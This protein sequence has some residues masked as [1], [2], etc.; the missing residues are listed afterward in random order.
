[1]ALYSSAAAVYTPAQAWA[2]TG[3]AT[4][5][6]GVIGIL[7]AKIVANRRARVIYNHMDDTG[8]ALLDALDTATKGLE[9]P[10]ADHPRSSI[11]LAS[12]AGYLAGNKLH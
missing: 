9:E 7:V 2:I 10:I 6:L 3:C 4:M 11:L 1:M 8:K 12:L 5:A